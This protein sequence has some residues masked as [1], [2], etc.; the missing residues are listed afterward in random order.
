M[1]ATSEQALVVA[2]TRSNKI[3]RRIDPNAFESAQMSIQ[4]AGELELQIEPHAPPRPPIS[5][6][7]LTRKGVAQFNTEMYA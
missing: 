6:T 2:G 1:L 4:R 3:N 5:A 7:M